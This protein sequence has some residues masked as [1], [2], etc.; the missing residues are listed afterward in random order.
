MLKNT[1]MHNLHAMCVNFTIVQPMHNTV[2]ILFIAQLQK[3]CI[4]KINC[5]VG[6]R[7]SYQTLGTSW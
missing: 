7:V 4:V 3:S 2:I 6:N 1:L 5:E